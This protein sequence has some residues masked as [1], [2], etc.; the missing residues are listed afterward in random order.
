MERSYIYQLV[1]VALLASLFTGLGFMFWIR[2]HAD[3]VARTTSS[4]ATQTQINSG[5][6][7]IDT[8]KKSNPAVVAIT[9]SKNVPTYE[10]YFQRLPGFFGFSI[11]SYR[12]NGTQKV[13][14]GGGSGFLV[15]KDGYIITNRHV[16]EDE[17]ADYTVFLNDGSKHSAE[18]ITRD[19]NLDIAI[20][21]INGNNFPFLP[22]GDS[23]KLEVGQSVIAIGNALAEFRNTV[24]L[25]IVSGLSRS[26]VASSGSGEAEQLDQLIQTD[27]AIN[28]GNS[29]GPLLNLNGEVIGVN[30]AVATSAENIGFAISGN[31]VK[32]LVDSIKK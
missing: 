28:P 29:G 5:N 9:I 31:S 21:K 3:S 15:S 2:S 4:L 6:V 14:V 18:V 8:V 26:I 32:I 16:V 23:N 20:I 30:V 24:S 13:D 11:P 25:G 10:R 22:F 27:A 1:V 19:E 17:N 7:V 12:Q